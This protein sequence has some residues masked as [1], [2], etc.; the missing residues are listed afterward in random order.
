MN[1]KKKDELKVVPHSELGPQ[2]E[3]GLVREWEAWKRKT[4][5]HRFWSELRVQ[6]QMKTPSANG[7]GSKVMDGMWVEGSTL[8]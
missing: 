4:Q 8:H 5:K 2:E 1:M 3:G 7:Q 6:G